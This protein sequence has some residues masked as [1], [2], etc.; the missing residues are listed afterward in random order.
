M[1]SIEQGNPMLTAVEFANFKCFKQRQIALGNLTLLT[2]LNGVGK[3]TVL[4]AMLLLR[5]S[6]LQQSLAHKSLLLNGSL[7]NLGTA[8]EVLYRGAE[9]NVIGLKL[10]SGPQE[11]EWKMRYDGPSDEIG[12]AHV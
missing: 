11:W 2:G 5:Q 3:S 7:I 10:L 12:R 9:E 1:D 6:F 8:G 4:Q